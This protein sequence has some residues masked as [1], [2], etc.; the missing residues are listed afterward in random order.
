MDF[1]NSCPLLRVLDLSFTRI[2]ELPVGI[3]GL[4]ELQYLNLENTYIKTLPKELGKL[5]KLRYLNLRSTHELVTIPV[6]V[7]Q[8]LSW[9]QVLNLFQSRI[10]KS[11]EVEDCYGDSNGVS[12]RDLESLQ[13]LNTLGISI[14]SVSFLQRFLNSDKLRQCTRLLSIKCS[15]LNSLPLSLSVLGNLKSLHSFLCS[16]CLDLVEWYFDAPVGRGQSIWHSSLEYLYLNNLPNLKII[17][18]AGLQPQ[19]YFRNLRYVAIS[20]CHLLKDLTWLLRLCRLQHIRLNRCNGME[21]IICDGVVMV[22]EE[23]IIFSRLHTIEIPSL[24]EFKSIC[25]NT[26]PLPSL[27]KIEVI[28]CPKL[29]KLPLDCSAM[30]T[31]ELIDH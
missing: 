12:L 28:H 15:R 1:S 19:L 3:T 21:E 8:G 2:E 23:L 26:L 22:E 24:P 11:W 18:K 27:K 17:E 14:S 6:E 9:L 13:S 5:W 16:D 25:A 20:D 10:C 29:K 31:L 30:N 4:V 7:I